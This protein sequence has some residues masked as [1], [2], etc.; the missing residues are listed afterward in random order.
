[1]QGDPIVAAWAESFRAG[2]DGDVLPPHSPGCVGCGPG[3]P[4]GLGLVVR[5]EGDSVVAEHTFD[6]R[7][8]GAP[9]VA[10]GGTVAMAF[11]DLF[12]FVLY[13]VGEL[14]VT[15]DLQVSY[16][17]PVRLDTPYVLRARYGERV[18]RRI[19]VSGQLHRADGTVIAAAAATFVIVDTEHFT[20]AAGPA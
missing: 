15:R 14:A 20:R 18:G 3:N 17:A 2:G 10:H 12:G 16:L 13:L 5:R 6:A 1:M 19:P 8:A 4:H 7:H 11:D 9:G